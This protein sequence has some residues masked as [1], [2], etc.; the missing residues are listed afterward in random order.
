[1][2][3]C[4][5][6]SK[7]GAVVL[8]LG[9]AVFLSSCKKHESTPAERIAALR[10]AEVQRDAAAKAQAI[11]E[12]QEMGAAA[13]PMEAAILSDSNPSL[14]QA[15]VDLLSHNGDPALMPTLEVI[16]HYSR[17]AD[18]SAEMVFA[19]LL[20]ASTQFLQQQLKSSDR[21]HKT[22]AIWALGHDPRVAKQSEAAQP[23]LV[24][25]L[26]GS[27]PD[28]R[29]FATDSIGKIGNATGHVETEV[30]QEALHDPTPQIRLFA[31]QGLGINPQDVM[32]PQRISRGRSGVHPYFGD[33]QTL[34][35]PTDQ[36]SLRTKTGNGSGR[37]SAR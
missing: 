21:T 1:M 33:P 14:R 27:D 6:F 35:P 26:R 17:D 13:V 37:R 25:I 2:R 11:A 24:A 23:A 28:L 22:S 9:A 15:A 18:D 3:C 34:W 8:A 7:Q 36:P 19:N 16:G 29:I 4:F 31:A 32:Q 30:L 12:L 5:D 10:K 20:P